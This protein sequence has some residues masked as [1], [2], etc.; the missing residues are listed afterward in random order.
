MCECERGRLGVR[1]ERREKPRRAS[2]RTL[3]VL[4]LQRCSMSAMCYVLRR[5]RELFTVLGREKNPDSP[6]LATMVASAH[7]FL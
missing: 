4:R 1:R 5:T 7:P 6:D 2:L 3:N